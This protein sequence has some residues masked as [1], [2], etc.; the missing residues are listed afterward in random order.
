MDSISPIGV[1]VGGIV[2]MVATMILTLPVLVSVAADLHLAGVPPALRTQLLNDAMRS[3]VGVYG[4]LTLLGAAGSV[5][6]GYV[7]AALAKRA[8]VLNGALTAYFCVGVSLWSI[9]HGPQQMP[10]WIHWLLL[11]VS[12]ALGALGGYWRQVRKASRD[13]AKRALETTAP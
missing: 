2:D 9:L 7:G 8:E 12:P 13:Q 10:L 6:G 3:N 1:I 5:I 11:P 4:L